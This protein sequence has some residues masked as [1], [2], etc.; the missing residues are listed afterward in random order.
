MY[1]RAACRTIKSTMAH[2][3]T[4]SLSSAASGPRHLLSISD[5]SPAE[6]TK[7]VLNASSHKTAVKAAFG[8]GEQPPKSL[9]GALT[10]KTVAMMFNKRSTRTRVSTEAAVQLMSGHPMFLGKD[11]I[12]LGVNESLYDTSVVISSMTSCMVAR[13]GAH[14]E[15]A[16]LAAHSS[17]PVINALSSDYHPLQTIADFQTIHES[18]PARTPSDASL[19]LEGLKVAWVGD[20]N[21][22][23]F[24]LAIGCVKMGVDI[25]VASPQGY[26]IPDAM[27]KVIVAAAE[28]V[29]KPG[30]LIETTVPE[31][32][33]KDADILVTD[34][35]VSMG[36]E[37][38]S[39]KRLKAFAGYQITNELA[40]RGGAKPD[41]K[42]MHCLPRH[43]EEVDDDV[44]YGPRSL[45]FPEAENR[46]WAAV[47]ALEAFVVNKGKIL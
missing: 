38:E 19:G 44:F 39:Q 34:T 41:W 14:K 11:D 37:V 8:A 16:D 29:A 46:L 23:L 33:I 6:F 32:A 40:K 17:V 35:W 43:P 9:H 15:V 1:S 45:V 18:F 28:G 26:G 25:A 21:N 47:A 4:R 13:V 24:D 27:R 7:L 2:L 12:Q 30:K 3:Q 10:G 36:Q 22:V 5:L 20:S 42:F 31:Q